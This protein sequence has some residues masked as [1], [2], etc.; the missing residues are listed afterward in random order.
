MKAIR[1]SRNSSCR[2]GRV[3][4][5]EAPA[6]SADARNLLRKQ[7][8][9]EEF[10]NLFG[11]FYVCGY[12]LGADAGATLSAAT[13]SSKSVETLTLTVT[14][15]VLFFEESLTI[16]KTISE[17]S[18][19]YSMTFTGFNTIES[20][21]TSTTSQSLSLAEQTRMQNTATAYL[22]T[23]GSIDEQVRTKLAHLGLKDGQELALSQCGEVCR[24]GLVVQLLLAPISRLNEF[25]SLLKK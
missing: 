8:G 5:N 19:S 20:T 14:V 3:I 7:G 16:S 25:V 15:R 6:L 12:E 23:V 24:S 17:E 21:A 9:L 13:H 22:K 2:C 1:A 18:Q 4:A 10:Y 11:D